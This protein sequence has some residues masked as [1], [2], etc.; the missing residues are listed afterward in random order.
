MAMRSILIA[1]VPLLIV[2]FALAQGPPDTERFI[3][4][5]SAE[6]R[7]GGRVLVL[8]LAPG[9]EDL[10]AVARYRVNAGAQV[11]ITYLTNGEGVIVEPS[12]RYPNQVA[13][14]ARERAYQAAVALD[15]DH[16]FLNLPYLDGA[17]SGDVVRAAWTQD[18]V[19][20]RLRA[21]VEEFQP[22]LIIVNGME[23]SETPRALPAEFL[24]LLSDV[25]DRVA[26]YRRPVPTVVA[27]AEG[28]QRSGTRSSR[29]TRAD[30]VTQTSLE[31]A[32][33]AY[34]DVSS[35]LPL[36]APTYRSLSAY[37]P[38]SFRSATDIDGLLRRSIPASVRVLDSLTRSFG[39]QVDAWKRIP[40]GRE[41]NR[42]LQRAVELLG[43]VD[44]WLQT[45]PREMERE[46]RILLDRR[47]ALE[48]VR[49]R[50]IG[51]EAFVRVSDSV[52]TNTQLTYL[53]IDSVRGLDPAGETQV[54]FPMVAKGW[55]LNETPENRAAL[56]AGTPYRLISSRDIP[57]DLP[58]E[59]AGLEQPRYHTPWY[60]F[61]IHRSTKPER[62][63]SLRV[64]AGLYGAPRF[65]VDVL[66]PIIMAV[67]GERLAVRITNNS[68]DGVRDTLE[69]HDAY[70]RSRPM[71]FRMN[72]KGSTEIDT[73]ELQFHEDYPEG[74]SFSDVLIGLDPVARFL[75]RKFPV[76][77]DSST[78]VGVLGDAGST[79]TGLAI[80][81]LGQ[82]VRWIASTGSGDAELSGL[83]TVVVPEW[84]G[85]SLRPAEW[86]ALR[87][88]AEQGGRVLVLAQHADV[89]T[90]LPDSPVRSAI[91][92]GS[93]DSTSVL[94]FTPDDRVLAGPNRLLDETWEGWINR[95]VPHR[96][97]LSSQTADVPLAVGVDAIP[98]IVRWTVGR[99][100]FTYVNLNL[101]HQ[102]LNAHPAAYRLLANLVAS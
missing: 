51:A 16:Y 37:P 12:I 67:P 27:V 74:T 90:G 17:A 40:Q 81:R 66:T 31:A 76:A 22:D 86:T 69:V 39:G 38:S 58:R 52:L 47:A 32:R 57:Y 75:V 41:A 5:R 23:R 48:A 102:L 62:S 64:D 91:P 43:Q 72:A 44:R 6:L 61:I 30:R 73:L 65:S 20:A 98:G 71:F 89:T 10:V 26:S 92:D 15:V 4:L 93:T 84:G 78:R 9:H 87:R 53:T 56:V 3:Q 70:V 28:R 42:L 55:I 99:G 82:P 19:R 85:A 11:R 24:P 95:R 96:L 83:Q 97:T 60:F 49:V 13:A 79:V 94:S 77:V 1:F 45:Q 34:S 59:I 101:H 29:R 21:Q 46:R 7:S 80:R 25:L 88:F 36:S 35:V 54:F 50:L 33:T 68:R 100:A 63:F 14:V 2:Q 8:A 18:T